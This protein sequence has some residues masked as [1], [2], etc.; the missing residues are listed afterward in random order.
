MRFEALGVRGAYL[1]EQERREDER[2]YFARV[3][4]EDEFERIGLCSRFVQANTGFNPRA[5]TLRGMHYQEAPAAEVKVVRCTRGSVFDVAVDLRPQSP[6]Y[7]AWAGVRLDAASGSMLYV[8]EGCAHGYLT[9]EDN[10]ELLYSTSHRYAPAAARGVR[11]DDPA[12]GINW[13][14]P[15][16]LVSKADQAW[17]AFQPG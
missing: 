6:T 4:C 12:F 1:I 3:F 11:H 15:I 8:P 14:A 9:L 10:T 7:L 13:P 17:P 2:G 5:G 16:A